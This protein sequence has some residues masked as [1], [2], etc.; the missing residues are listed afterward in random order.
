MKRLILLLG[1][2]ALLW[3]CETTEFLAYSGAQQNWP[4]APGAMVR[5]NLAVPVYYGLPP[6]PYTVLGEIATSKGQ[7]WAWSDVQSEAMEQAAVEAKRRG[8]DAIIVIS[9][10]ASVTGYYSTGSATVV[11]NTAIGSGV[12]MPVRTGHVRVTAIEVLIIVYRSAVPQGSYFKALTGNCIF[13]QSGIYVR[14]NMSEATN[15]QPL[16][17]PKHNPRLPNGHQ[18]RYTA[19]TVLRTR[20]KTYRKIVHLLADPY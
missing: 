6:R 14:L 20:P 1:A 5:Q 2:A 19:E 12:T 9:R 8:A 18:A 13:L 4:T 7:T 15:G 16:S 3:G 10:D 17:L 11:G